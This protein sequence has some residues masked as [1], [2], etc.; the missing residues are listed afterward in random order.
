M[1]VGPALLGLSGP[2]VRRMIHS[3][4]VNASGQFCREQILSMGQ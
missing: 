4:S 2:E 3:L 1:A